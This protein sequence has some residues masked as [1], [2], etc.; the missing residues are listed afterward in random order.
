MASEAE[1]DAAFHA[2]A[3]RL[4]EVPPE[5]RAK[6]VLDRRV[7]CRVSDL[8]L[9]WSARLS[10]EGLVGITTDEDDRK[11][12][13]RLSVASDD[14]VALVEGRTSVQKAVAMG[15]IRVQASPFDL[16]RLSSFL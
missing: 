9:T 12:Q 14:L 4:A 8:G 11:A 7:S 15:R 1:C 3:A 10:D 16:L 6:Y 5:I 13:I 2:L